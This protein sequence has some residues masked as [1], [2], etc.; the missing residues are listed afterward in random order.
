MSKFLKIQVVDDD[1]AYL[2]GGDDSR[3]L[4][5]CANPSLTREECEYIINKAKEERHF[6]ENEEAYFIDNM[7]RIFVEKELS[8]M[9]I[10]IDGR[11]NSYKPRKEMTLEEIEKE[12]GYK[13][14]IVTKEEK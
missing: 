8:R 7:I 3:L 12:L 11:N 1:Q 2:Y 5:P 6:H 13:V 4:R 14:K 10:S 9:T